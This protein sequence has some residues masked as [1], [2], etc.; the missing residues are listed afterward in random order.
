MASPGFHDIPGGGL[1]NGG[2]AA[3][4][5]RTTVANRMDTYLALH[6]HLARYQYPAKDTS[7]HPK[8]LR[9]YIGACL[10]LHTD[11]AI[12]GLAI[13]RVTV[14]DPERLRNASKE[15]AARFYRLS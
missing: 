6:R 8:Y 11:T 9:E 5:R 15:V 1:G 10:Q 13:S 3:A 12:P 4:S 14:A 7:V 2:N